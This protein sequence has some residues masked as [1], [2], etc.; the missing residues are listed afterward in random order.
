MFSG[1]RLFGTRN[2]RIQPGDLG[3]SALGMAGEIAHLA[4]LLT[5]VGERTGDREFDKVLRRSP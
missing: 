2:R 4:N 1:R 5:H 3:R